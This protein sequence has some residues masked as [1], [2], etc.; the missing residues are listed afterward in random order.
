VLEN[1]A[2]LEAHGGCYALGPEVVKEELASDSTHR[3]NTVKQGA[4]EPWLSG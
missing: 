4:W 1:K 3:Q 2:L